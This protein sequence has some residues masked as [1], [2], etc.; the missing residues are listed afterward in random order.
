MFRTFRARLLFWFLIFIGFNLITIAFSIAYLVQREKIQQ[1]AELV[2]EC[3]LMVLDNLLL[4][5]DFFS[6]ETKNT[7]FFQ[8][9]ES[10]YLKDYDIRTDSIRQVIRAI[11]ISASK[12]VQLQLEIVVKELQ[13]IDSLFRNL[14]AQ[15]KVRGYKD[16]SLEGAMRKDAHWLENHSNIAQASILSLRRHE[17][18]YIIRNEQSYVDKFNRLIGTI[19]KAVQSQRRKK[20]TPKD[21]TLIYLEGYQTKF[22]QLV[23][24]DQELGIKD[25]SGLKEKMDTQIHNL[26]DDF[27]DLLRVTET[28]KT[29]LFLRLR[30]IFGCLALLLIIGSIYLSW[31]IAQRITTPL[32]DLTTYITRFVDSNFTLES[33]NPNVRSKDEIGKLTQNFGILKEEVINRLKF[34]KQKVD[35][36]TAELADANGQLVKINKA[37]SRFVPKELLQ[38]LGKRS[39]EEVKLGDQTE[40][41]M[42]IMF[43]DIRSF[44]KISEGL[45]PQQNFDFINNYLNRIVPVIQKNQGVID[46][47]IGDSVMAL[48]PKGPESAVQAAVEF[49]LVLQQFNKEQETRG[50]DPIQIGV[51]IHTGKMILGTIGHDHRLE[52]TV[53]SDAVNVA[54]RVEGLTKYYKAKVI[55]TED[56]LSKLPKPGRFAYRLLDVVQVEGKTRSLAVYEVLSPSDHMKLSYQKLTKRGSKLL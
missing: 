7:S 26:E 36:R 51:G 29:K 19:Q 10:T 16:F 42:T 47:Y 18:D 52:T 23:A 21:S 31:I 48:F 6:Y 33:D 44:T 25:N 22:N 13:S 5:K 50:L 4:Q 40:R 15:V 53:I 56:T 55:A 3:Y 28:Q 49:D 32:T 30:L 34:F 2:E 45:S 38:L 20:S 43:T 11:R 37:N 1:N 14:V 46:K 12:P 8:S 54:S 27:R 9:D 17:K 39:I 35:E 41:E 24:L